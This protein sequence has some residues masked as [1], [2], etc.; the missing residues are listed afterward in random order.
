MRKSNRYRV[1]IDKNGLSDYERKVVDY[2]FESS[3]PK[4]ALRRVEAVYERCERT[5]KRIPYNSRL[6][7]EALAISAETDLEFND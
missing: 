1:T 6:F 4:D 2:V 3:S 7:L 5:N